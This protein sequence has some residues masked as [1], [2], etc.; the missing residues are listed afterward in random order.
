M[1][2]LPRTPPSVSILDETTTC[3]LAL[4]AVKTRA[5]AASTAHF[6]DSIDL[7]R[8]VCVSEVRFRHVTAKTPNH[9]CTGLLVLNR[10][11]QCGLP[12]FVPCKA[13][14]RRTMRSAASNSDLL[15]IRLSAL[16]A[17]ACRA[18]P[19]RAGAIAALPQAPQSTAQG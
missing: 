14:E 19:T 18:G 4:Q 16:V 11:H 15:V 17:A 5:A 1:I 8:V 9:K 10:C 2:I 12:A 3:A 13:M 7:P 6:F